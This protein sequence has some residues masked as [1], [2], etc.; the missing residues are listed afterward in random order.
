MT[1][2]TNHLLRKFGLT[3]RKIL[4]K[5]TPWWVIIHTQNPICTY[6]FGP[7]ESRTEAAIAQSGY[8]E[9]LEWEDAEDIQVQIQQLSP[10]KLT[11]G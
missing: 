5:P 7:F 6:Y 3:L 8:I 10:Q 4:I 11:L 1:N 9:D 2:L